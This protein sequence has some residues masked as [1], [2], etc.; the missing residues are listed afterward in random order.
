MLI[1]KADTQTP[2]PSGMAEKEERWIFWGSEVFSEQFACLIFQL[3]PRDWKLK[4]EIIFLKEEEMIRE[5]QRKA[6][7]PLASNAWVSREPVCETPI[8]SEQPNN[9][10][11]SFGSF[12]PSAWCWKL[13][14][15]VHQCRIKSWRQRFGWS[16]KEKLYCFAGQ[17]GLKAG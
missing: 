8:C 13:S 16:R 15:S 2:G 11:L 14:F 17:R 4:A 10:H 9:S 12:I 1:R 3:T 5:A 6:G 7:I